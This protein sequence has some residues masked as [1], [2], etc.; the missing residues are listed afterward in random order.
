MTATQQTLILA[1]S[2]I[3]DDRHQSVTGIYKAAQAERIMTT[4]T[5]YTTATQ[6]MPQAGER[7]V[8]AR[9]KGPARTAA[10]C[11]PDTAW[12]NVTSNAP[13]QYREI[14]TAVLD[15]AAKTILNRHLNSF[16]MWPVDIDIAYYCETA[17][18]EE[19]LGSNN[20]WL[21][22]EQ[23]EAAWHDSATRKAWITSSNYASNAAYRKA[24]AHYE[25]LITKLAGKTSA[26]QP[27]DLDLILAKIKPEDLTTELGSFVVRRIDALRN[28]PAPAM[29]DCDLL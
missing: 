1:R 8:V 10:I 20:E 26:Y 7:L 27:S 23:I 4:A 5:I 15:N 24:V 13:A 29:V 21:S 18:L 25:S 17:L 3:V 14:L 12:N 28:K 6:A 16:S 2:A 22:K 19:A 11:V 9:F